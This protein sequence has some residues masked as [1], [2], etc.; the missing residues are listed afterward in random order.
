M[1]LDV[2]A[3]A[4]RVVEMVGQEDQYYQWLHEEGAYA[5]EVDEEEDDF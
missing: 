5:H 1:A 4:N 2:V 3:A